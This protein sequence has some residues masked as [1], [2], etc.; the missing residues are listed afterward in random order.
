MSILQAFENLNIWNSKGKRAPHKPLML[1]YMLARV[2]DSSERMLDFEQLEQPVKDLLVDFGNA[3]TAKSPKPEYPFYHLKNS[4]ADQ[5][6]IWELSEVPDLG[7]SPSAKQLRGIKGGFTEE[8]YAF[9][10]Q[11]PQALLQVVQQLLDEHFPPSLHDMILEAVDFKLE[12]PQYV[13]SK[14]RV[15]DT[16]FREKVLKAYDY[17]CAVCGYQL[18]MKKE[19]GRQSIGLE[20][21]HVRWHAYNGPDS[22][23]NGLALCRLHHVLLDVGAYTLSLPQWRLQVS[24]HVFGAGLHTHILPYADQPLR[25]PKAYREE[26]EQ[27]WAWHVEEVFKGYG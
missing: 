27:H 22:L 2:V 8:V 3:S 18:F 11:Q 17:R 4:K 13:L 9:F 24:D 16:A 10:K 19:Q 15:R 6:P 1:L 14:R 26:M 23:H 25:I 5:N 12:Q 21:A 20:A 7:Y